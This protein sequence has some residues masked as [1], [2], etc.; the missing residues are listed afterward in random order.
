MTKEALLAE[1]LRLSPEERID[2][3]GQVWD[4][5]AASPD[6]V[7]VPEWHMK[8]LEKRLKEPAPRYLPW[9]EVRDRLKGTE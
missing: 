3:I 5:T 7:Q 9:D 1:I 2:L 4:A 8:E 6:Q